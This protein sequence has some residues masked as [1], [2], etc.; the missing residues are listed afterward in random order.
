MPTIDIPGKICPHCDGIRWRSEYKKLAGGNKVLIYRCAVRAMERSKKWK[1][2]NP[3]NVRE[4]NVASCRKRRA[5]GYYKTPKEQE[6]SRLRAQKERN[7]LSNNYIYKRIL[8]DP[9]IKNVDRSDIPQWL[10]ETKRKQLLLIRQIKNNGK[11][12]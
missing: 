10:I 5:N 7:T 2:N 1:K 3:D 4:H 9:E 6:R 12:N 8:D 11:D